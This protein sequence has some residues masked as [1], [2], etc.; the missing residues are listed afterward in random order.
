VEAGVGHWLQAD[1]GW[2]VSFHRRVSW[3]LHPSDRKF[4]RLTR[5]QASLG[6]AHQL[7][8]RGARDRVAQCPE[9]SSVSVWARIFNIRVSDAHVVDSARGIALLRPGTWW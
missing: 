2:A 3:A 1:F 4:A 8:R 7:G 6:W 5:L 9:I